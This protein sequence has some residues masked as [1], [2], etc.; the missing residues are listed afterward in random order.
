M[1][2][3]KY[4]LVAERDRE[5]IDR[6]WDTTDI[7]KFPTSYPEIVAERDGEIIGFVATRYDKSGILIEPM[8]CQSAVVYLK[9]WHAM[10]AVLEKAGVTAYSFRVEP[11]R[12]IY[13]KALNKRVKRGWIK[14][15][16]YHGGFTWYQREI[17]LSA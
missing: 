14:C 12:V 10:E 6:L 3:T 17:Q 9:L 5:H 4:R 1:S 11:H 7:P 8:I 13:E 15:L 2:K 16:G